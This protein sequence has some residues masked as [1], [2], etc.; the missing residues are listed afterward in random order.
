M[1]MLIA[2]IDIELTVNIQR[3]VTMALHWVRCKFEISVNFLC[4]ILESY[5]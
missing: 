1:V 5:A 2:D 3:T 4:L